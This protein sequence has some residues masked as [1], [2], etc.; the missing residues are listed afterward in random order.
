MPAISILINEFNKLSWR[1]NLGVVYIILRFII[2]HCYV[3]VRPRAPFINMFYF[4][5]RMDK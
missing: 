2:F 3:I 4:N 5:P 1:Y